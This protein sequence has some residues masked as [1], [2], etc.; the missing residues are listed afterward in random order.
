VKGRGTLPPLPAALPVTAQLINLDSGK[1][2]S[3][4]FTMPRQN[5]SD[6]FLAVIP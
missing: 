6:R 3:S 2:W 5:L 1:C 4:E